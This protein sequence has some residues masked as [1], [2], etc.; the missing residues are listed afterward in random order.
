MSELTCGLC[1]GTSIEPTGL[2]NVM[3]SGVDQVRCKTCGVKFFTHNPKLASPVEFYNR[4][5]YDEF[6]RKS[7]EYGSPF[8]SD[9]SELEKYRNAH[10]SI[11][12]QSFERIRDLV[13]GADTVYEVG[14]GYGEML[15]VAQ[16]M[17]FVVAGCDISRAGCQRAEASG[18]WVQHALFIE[19]LGLDNQHAVIMWDM[20]EHSETPGADLDKAHKHLR[21]GGC[22]LIKTFYDEWHRDKDLNLSQPK[23]A[24]ICE[25]ERTGYYGPVAHP[26]HFETGVLLRALEC[27]GFRIADVS[28]NLTHGQVT[29]YALKK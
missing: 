25:L 21:Q 27:R 28:H 4:P 9:D 8:C 24:V 14:F 7:V 23:T 19:A 26:Y 17:G 6:I 16:D 2:T 11:F 10:K 12:R 22:L 13:P 15:L 18:L 20:I 1:G 5:A 3:N 29:V